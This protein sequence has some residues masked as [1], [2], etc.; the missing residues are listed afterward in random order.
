MFDIT[1][2]YSPKPDQIIVFVASK[3]SPIFIYRHI[4]AVFLTPLLNTKLNTLLCSQ[5]LDSFW[6]LQQT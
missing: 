5:L 4:E 6:A 1:G 2:S 3:F